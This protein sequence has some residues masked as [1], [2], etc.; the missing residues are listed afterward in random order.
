MPCAM[1]SAMRPSI[2]SRKKCPMNTT[3]STRIERKCR[4]TSRPVPGTNT[5]ISDD[6]PRFRSSPCSVASFRTAGGVSKS[7][8]QI[9]I[10][11]VR[12]PFRCSAC[13]LGVNPVSASA[14]CTSSMVFCFNPGCPLSTRETVVRA[15][16]T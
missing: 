16:P 9:P 5:S 15:S 10:I 1:S 13:A 8:T 11:A 7:S 12:L 3:A 6:R 14:R 4:T 2:S